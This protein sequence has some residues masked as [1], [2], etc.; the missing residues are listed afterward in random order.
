M[1]KEHEKVL[2]QYVLCYDRTEILLPRG[3]EIL[4]VSQLHDRPFVVVLTDT[5]LT[6]QDTRVFH[7]IDLGRGFQYTPGMRFIG[8]I[9]AMKKVFCA[10]EETLGGNV[11]S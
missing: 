10:F 1:G 7:L 3:A 5:L 4:S 8:S 9:F 2:R 6:T 11:S